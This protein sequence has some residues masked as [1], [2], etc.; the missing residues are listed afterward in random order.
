MIRLIVILVA[1]L[2]SSTVFASPLPSACAVQTTNQTLTG[3][4][5]FTDISGLSLASGNFT[6]GE[7]YLLIA[8]G[9]QGENGTRAGVRF[10]HGG[11][12][13]VDYE[14]DIAVGDAID[15]AS[16]G[17]WTVWTAVSGEAITLQQM[18]S[19]STDTASI[20]N[21]T[22]CAFQLT[23]AGLTENTDWFFVERANNDALTTT[24]L[25]GA[26]VTFSTPGTWWVLTWSQ[27]DTIGTNPYTSRLNRSGEASSTTPT[28]LIDHNQTAG[29]WGMT[30]GRVFS[31]TASNTFTEQSASSIANDHTRLHS[32]I[33]ALNLDKFSAKGAAYTDASVTLTT[34][35]QFGT[36]IQTTSVTPTTTTDLFSCAVFI[37]DHTVSGGEVRSRLQVDNTDVPATQTSDAYVYSHNNATDTTVDEPIFFCGL[38]SAQTAATHTIDHDGSTGNGADVKYRQLVSFTL[39]LAPV[40]S[41]DGQLGAVMLP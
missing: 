20:D 6:A 3:T 12:G 1:L 7:K 13:F 21:I 4:T 24:F 15:R 8:T 41:A 26:S 25:D 40:A 37:F 10:A 9:I 38:A 5:A 17:I 2:W 34:A 16:A 31:T 22:L 36:N 29:V 27:I 28:G 32:A 33:F 11:T 23:H 19:V 18:I 39:E 35:V 14:L 30:L